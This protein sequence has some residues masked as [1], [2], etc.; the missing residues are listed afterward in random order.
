MKV[1]TL[2][3]ASFPIDA[4]VALLVTIGGRML[5]RFPGERPVLPAEFN[6]MMI[7][8]KWFVARA[9]DSW[10]GQDWGKAG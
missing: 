2:S 7:E 5:R 6:Q 8:L 4:G 9:M 1:F 3:N 10:V